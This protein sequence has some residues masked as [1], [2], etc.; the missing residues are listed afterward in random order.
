MQCPTCSFWV[1]CGEP[2][3]VRTSHSEPTACGCLQALALARQH[4]PPPAPP[5]PPPEVRMVEQVVEVPDPAATARA[6]RLQAE[7]AQLQQE[8]LE[9]ER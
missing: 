1:H 6:Q 3:T 9:L 7:V 2:E 4:A 8:R 5:P